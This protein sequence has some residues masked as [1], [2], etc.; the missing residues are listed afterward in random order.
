MDPKIQPVDGRWSVLPRAVGA[1]RRRGSDGGPKR[2]AHTEEE[3]DPG[4]TPARPGAPAGRTGG[5]PVPKDGGAT[6]GGDAHDPDD[7]ED[8]G[9]RLDLTA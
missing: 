7:P 8:V 9:G 1:A 4:S 2:D 3:P 5:A 6:P